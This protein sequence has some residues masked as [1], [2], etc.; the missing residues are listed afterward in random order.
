MCMWMYEKPTV[1][2]AIMTVKSKQTMTMRPEKK[3]E[4]K[5]KRTWQLETN[6]V[7]DFLA[8][9]EETEC[10][11]KTILR[12]ISAPIHKIS[13]RK[14]WNLIIAKATF[15]LSISPV[16]LLWNLF[17]SRQMSRYLF[18][19]PVAHFIAKWSMRCDWL[20]SISSHSIFHMNYRLLFV[21]IF[22]SRSFPYAISVLCRLFLPCRFDI[23]SFTRSLTL[24]FF[25]SLSYH[26]FSHF[27]SH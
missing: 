23:L 6:E 27:S 2:I 18:G 7:V 3:E 16:A 15:S 14:L 26:H 10:R 13:N 1:I 24:V 19:R 20:T 5:E 4:E 17:I 11:Q 12:W 8:K 21:S 22:S 9:T 25:L